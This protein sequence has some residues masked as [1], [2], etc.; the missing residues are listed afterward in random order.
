MSALRDQLT[1][2]SIKLASILDHKV[3]AN[4]VDN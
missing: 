1:D 4:A 3:M 2:Q